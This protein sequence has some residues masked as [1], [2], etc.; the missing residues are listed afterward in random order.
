MVGVGRFQAKVGPCPTLD[1]R[2]SGNACPLL[3]GCS[4]RRDHFLPGWSKSNTDLIPL[5]DRVIRWRP[6]LVGTQLAVR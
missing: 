1:A 3:R 5:L 6:G 4:L 2:A